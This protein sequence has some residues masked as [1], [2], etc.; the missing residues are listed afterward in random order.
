MDIKIILHQC[1]AL[2]S[3]FCCVGLGYLIYYQDVRVKA[4]EEE[5]RG[6]HLIVA[7]FTD[8]VDGEAGDHRGWVL[9]AHSR[10]V[11]AV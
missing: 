8:D 6:D 7:P 9:Q 2:L 11:K 1:N 3:N 4:E 5:S 10:Q